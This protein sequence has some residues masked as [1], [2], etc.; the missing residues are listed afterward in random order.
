MRSLCSSLLALLFVGCASY[1]VKQ[2]LQPFDPVPSEQVNAGKSIPA[3]SRTSV[4]SAPTEVINPYFSDI[5]KDYVY[6]A[7]IA[8]FD[9][10][11]GGLLII[12]KLGPAH[13][14]IVF[15][16]EMGNTI[17][18]FTFKEDDFKVN[19]ILRKMDRKILI[20]LLKRDF[21][22]LI[23]AHPEVLE[24]FTDQKDIVRETNILSKKHYF[25]FADTRLHKIVRAGDGKEKVVFLFSEV[26][27]GLAENV[28]ILHKTIPLTITLKSI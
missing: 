7:K 28:R 8:A 26:K 4:A 3:T 11:F 23:E 10:S 2:G 1:P 15:T 17:F 13:H 5:S 14:R 22:V 18:D 25:Y 12:K 27:D 6:K 20:T 16:T 24:T 19:R 9:T 21:K